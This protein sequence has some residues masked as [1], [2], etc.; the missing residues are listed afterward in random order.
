MIILIKKTC[1]KYNIYSASNPRIISI[2]LE[3][4]DRT[5]IIGSKAK[6]SESLLII[7]SEY[8]LM[9]GFLIKYLAK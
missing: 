1:R 2:F 8:E 6:L 4:L 9:S 7:I 5:P 3:N